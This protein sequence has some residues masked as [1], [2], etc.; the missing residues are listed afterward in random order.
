MMNINTEISSRF[1]SFISDWDYRQYL[2]F[3]GYGSGK[4]Y[5]IAQKLIFKLLEEKRTLLVIREVFETIK[6]SCYELF[7]TVLKDMDLLSDFKERHKK[8]FEPKS[9]VAV[10]SPLE[11]RFPNGSRI[12]F[13]GADNPEKLKSIVGVSIIWVEEC[14]EISEETYLEL[15]GRMRG[16]GLSKHIILSC[17][18]IG[19]ENW[20]YRH[21]F[22]RTD[23]LG[24]EIIIQDEEE[25]YKR[26]TLVNK[27]NGVYYCHSIPNDN[28]FLDAGYIPLLD[29]YRVVDRHKWLV[30]RWGRFGVAGIRVLPNFRVATN[31]RNFVKTV[32][33]ISAHF[34]FFGFDFGF[35]DSYNALI[36]CCVDDEQKILYIYDEVYINHIT[37]DRFSRRLDVR[38][39]A[40]TAAR[41]EKA[42]SADCEEP[43]TIQYYRQQGFP[44]RKCRKVPGSRLQNT[45]KMQRFRYIVCS[46][47]CTNTIRELQ[48]LTF[49]KDKNGNLMQDEFNIDP[50]TF[51]A[52]W[53]ALDNYTVA[54][55]KDMKTNTRR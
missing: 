37:D 19:K 5:S 44:I 12:I 49:K 3:G 15:L 25:V 50:H 2:L 51:S 6:E 9:V 41:C 17:N 21:F 35:E 4:S 22:R 45:K 31:A 14:S 53:Y 29:S 11:I 24:R 42:I 28:P 30:A 54:D 16:R 1:T 43:K 46:P 13:K 48:T 34:H 7:K 10:L 20:V 26:R 38:H 23:N 32:R 47:K 39:I 8:K 40:S 27:S 36:S 55:I 33:N 18:P 52:L